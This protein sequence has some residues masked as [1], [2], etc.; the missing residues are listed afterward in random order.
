MDHPEQ[1]TA[2]PVLYEAAY[3]STEVQLWDIS[4][5][6]FYFYFSSSTEGNI[7]LL[8]PLHLYL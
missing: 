3:K 1:S 8:T 2:H 5:L 7:A 4:I 6:Y